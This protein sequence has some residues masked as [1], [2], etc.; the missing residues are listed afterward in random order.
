[1]LKRYSLMLQKLFV[2]N[3]KSH[4]MMYMIPCVADIELFDLVKLSHIMKKIPIYYIWYCRKWY[5]L[6]RCL[7]FIMYIEVLSPSK[8]TLILY[9]KNSEIL[10]KMINMIG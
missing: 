2:N 7:A 6:M 4:P 3:F 9:S 10:E 5:L 1:M 8:F